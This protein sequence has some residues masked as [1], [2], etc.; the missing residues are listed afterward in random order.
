MLSLYGEDNA[1]DRLVGASSFAALAEATGDRALFLMARSWRIVPLLECR[2]F[3][4]AAVEVEAVAE[5]AS[6]LE[7][8]AYLLCA[9]L[10]RAVEPLFVCGPDHDD[11][12][13]ALMRWVADALRESAPVPMRATAL[14][15]LS[16][17]CAALDDPGAAEILYALALHWSGNALDVAAR[18]SW[19]VARA[20]GVLSACAKHAEDLERHLGAALTHAALAS[21]QELLPLTR[22]GY[23][24]LLRDADPARAVSL[25]GESVHAYTALGMFREQD[26][27]EQL[28]GRLRGA[29]R[30]ADRAPSAARRLQ[31]AGEFWSFEFEGEVIHLRDSKGL[32]DI[33]HLLQHPGKT[34][35]ALELMDARDLRYLACR[36]RH[37]DARTLEADGLRVWRPSDIVRSDA[38][39][40]REYAER[41]G[42]LQREID[43]AGQVSDLG[44]VERCQGELE[45][46]Q[47]EIDNGRG[48]PTR[49]SA[50]PWERAR[51]AVSK[52]IRK[53]IRT[54]ATHH[55]RL[56]THLEESIQTGSA[57]SYIPREPAEWSFDARIEDGRATREVA[58][59][60][61]K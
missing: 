14:S 4:A 40:I 33:F 27:A 31:R 20:L 18:D 44:R 51:K 1:L 8:S 59:L 42:E 49:D 13:V 41:V 28:L 2:E 5:L 23:A 11:T 29:P 35:S 53:E 60:P 12:R 6:S 48:F 3:S 16:D 46:L 58:Q 15:L 47:Q 52:R 39:A 37:L 38:R 19:E 61:A 34:V 54:I 45:F 43:D 10:L 57:C 30:L 22:H 50:S 55:P 17:L 25:L 24:A 36:P 32:R 9:E 21:Q 56:G 7:E 26:R